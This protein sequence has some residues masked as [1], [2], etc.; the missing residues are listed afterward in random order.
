MQKKLLWKLYWHFLTLLEDIL[1]VW[2]FNCFSHKLFPWIFIL[3]K[4]RGTIPRKT[5]TCFP[6]FICYLQFS[7]VVRNI[8]RFCRQESLLYKLTKM[9]LF[10][11]TKQKFPEFLLKMAVRFLLCLSSCSKQLSGFPIFISISASVFL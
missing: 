6:F 4:N 9:F 2:F 5:G 3:P 10:P 11:K 1:S 8:N 7:D